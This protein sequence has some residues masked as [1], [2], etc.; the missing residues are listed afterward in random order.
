V[1]ATDAIG[2]LVEMVLTNY[3]SLTLL[4]LLSSSFHLRRQVK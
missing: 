4:T 1:N 2:R 3:R